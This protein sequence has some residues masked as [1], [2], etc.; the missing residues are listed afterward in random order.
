MFFKQIF[1]GF[2]FLRFIFY[3]K[4]SETKT[5]AQISRFTV[6]VQNAQLTTK[7]HNLL[8]THKLCF[9]YLWS[10]CTLRYLFSATYWGMYVQIRIIK[11][12]INWLTLK[13]SS[14]KQCTPHRIPYGLEHLKQQKW[15]KVLTQVI[16]WI[17]LLSFI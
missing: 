17:L 6:V 8:V 14:T 11:S 3:S 2:Q 1:T 5:A 15:K 12:C 4:N 7:K 13:T 16:K 10:K 9:N